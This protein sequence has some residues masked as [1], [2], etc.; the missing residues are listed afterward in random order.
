MA[1]RR[2]L[3]VGFLLLFL[4]G[5]DLQQA[6]RHSYVMDAGAGTDGHVN[7]RVRPFWEGGNASDVT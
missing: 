5:G 1:S 4:A 2:K 6:F 7:T 3:K